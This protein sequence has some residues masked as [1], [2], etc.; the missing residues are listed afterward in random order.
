MLRDDLQ[1]ALKEAMK[2]KNMPVVGAV[3]MIIAGLKEKDVEARGKGKEKADDAELLAMMQ[4]MIKQRTE[5]AKIYLEGN[6]PEL[7]EKEQ[8]EIVVI[9]RFL[10]KQL[11]DDEVKAVIE[12][13]IKSVGATSIKDMGKVMASLK[14]NYAGQ[15]DSGKASGVIKSL[16]S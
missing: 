2:E 11:S 6:R 16:L 5:S 10:P 9:E 13:T 8:A 7:A 1:N 14:A 3:R 12:E 4:T 15:L